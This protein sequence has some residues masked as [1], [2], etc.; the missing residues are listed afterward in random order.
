MIFIPH[1]SH[2]LVGDFFEEGDRAK[3]FQDSVLNLSNG[4]LLLIGLA[5]KKYAPAQQLLALLSRDCDKAEEFLKKQ[6]KLQPYPLQTKV[7][8]GNPRSARNVGGLSSVEREVDQE[9]K[10]TMAMNSFVF[11]DA[12]SHMTEGL[13]VL[14]SLVNEG[15]GPAENFRSGFDKH[16]ID[17]MRQAKLPMYSLTVGLKRRCERA[18][19]N[20]FL[21]KRAGQSP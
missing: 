13:E 7:F 9:M 19:A 5:H 15:Y 4:L 20:N 1:I 12:V 17:S 18:I 21:S 14:N 10:T 6:I 3:K 16:V 8:G 11:D 2:G